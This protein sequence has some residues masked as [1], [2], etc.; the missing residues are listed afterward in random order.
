MANL[1]YTES[2]CF[3]VIS[4]A[5]NLKMTCPNGR[6]TQLISYGITPNVEDIV[7]TTCRYDESSPAAPYI[8]ECYGTLIK[9]EFDRFFE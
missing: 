8:N 2:K 9:D 7:K 3:S 1:G 5:A 6:M 4:A